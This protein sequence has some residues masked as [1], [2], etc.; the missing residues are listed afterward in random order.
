VITWPLGDVDVRFSYEP[1]DGVVVVSLNASHD[2]EVRADT[3]VFVLQ[4]ADTIRER[5]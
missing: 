5:P 2:L 1:G 3:L 4:D